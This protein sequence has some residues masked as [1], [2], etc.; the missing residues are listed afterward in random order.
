MDSSENSSFSFLQCIVTLPLMMVNAVTQPS[1][2]NLWML[3]LWK[4]NLSPQKR[5]RPLQRFP[6][7][8]QRFLFKTP[9]FLG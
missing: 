3:Q 6:V 2:F 4:K 1:I 7:F 5:R 8:W 9:V